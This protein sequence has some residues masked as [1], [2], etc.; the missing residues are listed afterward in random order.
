MSQEPWRPDNWQEKR[1]ECRAAELALCFD[2]ALDSFEAGADAML[3]ILKTKGILLEFG[4]IFDVNDLW[5][6]KL[7]HPH[8]ALE[9]TSSKRSWLVCIPEEE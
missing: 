1:N 6:D 5:L 2:D 8:L 7:D 3:E 9:G 4:A